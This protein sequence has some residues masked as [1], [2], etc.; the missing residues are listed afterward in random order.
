MQITIPD[1]CTHFKM[2]D[3]GKECDNPFEKEH[4]ALNA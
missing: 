1:A 2:E 4:I 3:V